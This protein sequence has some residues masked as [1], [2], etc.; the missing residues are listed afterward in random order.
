MSES[1]REGG[2]RT[3]L[4]TLAHCHCSTARGQRQQR[5]QW[6]RIRWRRKTEPSISSSVPVTKSLPLGP[7]CQV[8]SKTKKEKTSLSVL[9]KTKYWTL[10]PA[11]LITHTT[12][13]PHY[14]YPSLTLTYTY[15][16]PHSLKLKHTPLLVAFWTSV[17]FFF[18]CVCF[19][20]YTAFADLS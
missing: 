5:Q 8:G 7:S 15:S 12:H 10:T 20:F 16:H 11:R 14:F 18:V 2:R 6:K 3:T 19:F 4:Q 1:E 17:Y 13:T 9:H